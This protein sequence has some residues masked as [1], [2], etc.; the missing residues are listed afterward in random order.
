MKT[1]KSLLLS[2]DTFQCDGHF[3]YAGLTPYPLEKYVCKDFVN[4]SLIVC[5][6][7]YVILVR[8]DYEI[9]V[10]WGHYSYS[11]NLI[12][13]KPF[14]ENPTRVELFIY[15]QKIRDF[16]RMSRKFVNIKVFQRII[17]DCDD[18]SLKFISLHKLI[19]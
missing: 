11:S 12:T 19:S 8:N 16:D 10:N 5:K 15:N 1:L 2:P 17:E 9:K 6:D 14:E 3:L 13:N 4:N 7:R 18:N